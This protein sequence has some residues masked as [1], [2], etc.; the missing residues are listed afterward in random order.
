[1]KYKKIIVLSLF[2]LLLLSACNEEKHPL[3]DFVVNED[4]LKKETVI[5]ESPKSE[6]VLKMESHNEKEKKEALI[7]YQNSIAIIETNEEASNLYDEKGNVNENTN[8]S[9]K[10]ED[11]N[12]WDAMVIIDILNEYEIYF[13]EKTIL[14]KDLKEDGTFNGESYYENQDL[15]EMIFDIDE[16]FEEELNSEDFIDYYNELKKLHGLIKTMIQKEEDNFDLNYFNMVKKQYE[17]RKSQFLR[18]VGLNKLVSS[19]YFRLTNE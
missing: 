18:S 11:F 15:N 2:S 14:S 12:K 10:L 3:E 17:Q 16:L 4:D 13:D 7:E 19:E 8:I 5:K 9:Q 1:M 6:E